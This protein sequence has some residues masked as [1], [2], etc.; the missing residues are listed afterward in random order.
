MDKIG[1]HKIV[2][3]LH[4]I[5]LHKTVL[6]LL[7]FLV[8]IAAAVAEEPLGDG[9][10]ENPF[11]F[12]SMEGG[13]LGV[14]EDCALMARLE[15]G[16]GTWQFA[17]E[18][19]AFAVEG[20][21]TET[22]PFKIAGGVKGIVCRYTAGIV[23]YAQL[24]YWDPVAR[25]VG[26]WVVD[27]SSIPF[28]GDGSEENPWHLE[29]GEIGILGVTNA[30][31]LMAKPADGEWEYYEFNKGKY[32]FVRGDG[33]D[34]DP[35]RV[36]GGVTGVM[37]RHDAGADEFPL[38]L[39]RWD[40]AKTSTG[41]WVDVAPAPSQAENSPQ[42]AIAQE[43]SRVTAPSAAPPS[44]TSIQETR[45]LTQGLSRRSQE[46]DE[47]W[48]KIR[49]KIGVAGEALQKIWH[50]RQWK[51]FEEVYLPERVAGVPVESQAIVNAALAE[52]AR[53]N[54]GE[55]KEA[56]A[57]GKRIVEEEYF[58]AAGASLPATQP[59]S[60]AFISF[61]MKRAGVSDFPVSTQHSAYFRTI[62]N[63][64]VSSCTSY[65]LSQIAAIGAG[66]V[67]CKGREYTVDYGSFPEENF[68]AHCDIVTERIGEGLK[69]IGGNIND[70]VDVKDL[71]LHEA[72]SAPYFGFFRCSAGAIGAPTAYDRIIQE[73]AAQI[74]V[75]AALIKAVMQAE[76]SFNPN[77][78]ST[79][80]CAGLMQICKTSAKEEIRVQ[81]PQER[82]K[83]P[84]QC[85]VGTNRECLISESVP[86]CKVC[87]GGGSCTADDRFDPRKNIFSGTKTLKGK[88]D[89]IPRNMCGVECQ[90]AAY[91]IGQGVIR[92]AHS[93]LPAPL[94]PTWEN[95]YAQIT[96][97]LMAEVS[98]KGYGTWT[99]ER[100]QEKIKNLKGYVERIMSNYRA[101]QQRVS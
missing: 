50:N 33:S 93:A 17:H 30:C 11:H 10:E 22:N 23:D 41:G 62:K 77:D 4:K 16:E 46:I 91:N 12:E 75:E 72:G 94:E 35:F 1:S 8:L 85:M 15:S 40:P 78:I 2:L 68:P 86:W 13:I 5:A 61:V 96:P 98:P 48:Q 89:T 74:G 3:V 37:C 66:D 32:G 100:R 24:L 36:D 67:L 84:Q 56:D 73:A 60:A 76:S 83:G 95:V 88:M 79:T 26:G 31:E 87:S 43:F 53:W 9:S 7:L 39:L 49:D 70:N 14:T 55:L 44:E 45:E 20:E 51:R 21:G 92:K 34:N 28:G 54:Y 90:V 59:W 64:E 65:P 82:S 99:V 38:Q 81:C 101:Y 58:G 47:V 19:T 71:T 57:E 69:L 29:S 6:L 25:V 80:G 63:R 42:G 18:Q 97:E 52:Y 27:P